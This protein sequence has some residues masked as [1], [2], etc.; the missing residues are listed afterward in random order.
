VFYTLV[1]VYVVVNDSFTGVYTDCTVDFF[2][3]WIL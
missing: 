2:A 1:T 3:I